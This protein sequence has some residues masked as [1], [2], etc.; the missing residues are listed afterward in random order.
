MQLKEARNTAEA[1]VTLVETLKARIQELEVA[2]SSSQDKAKALENTHAA[3]LASAAEATSVEHESLLQAQADLKAITEEA[4]RLKA[5]HK[6]A[7][8]GSTTQVKVLEEQAAENEE[9]KSQVA[10]LKSEKEDNANK[11]SELEIEILEL[12]ET[13]EGLEDTR[14]SL[15]RRIT[16]LEDDLAKS[17][18]ASALAAEATSSKEKEYL[19]Q[20]KEQVERHEEELATRSKRHDEMIASLKS[21]EEQHA[22]TSKAFEQAEQDKISIEQVHASKLSEL[23]QAH[24]AQRDAQSAEFAKVK[25]E[26]EVCLIYISQV[27]FYNLVYRI[28]K[29]FIIP[30]L[31]SSR[32]NMSNFCKMLLNK[33]R[34][35]SFVR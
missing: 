22:D 19:A 29:L 5:A 7:L 6:Q 20:L 32:L 21:L 27:S 30:R 13:Q 4:G 31:R 23:Q 11:L 26:L 18:V 3:D 24:A 10:S 8:E 35:D 15:E 9:L 12:K 25:A 14:D 34:S 33:P 2:L 28:K 16:T 1:Q 17:A